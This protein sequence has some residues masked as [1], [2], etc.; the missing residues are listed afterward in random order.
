MACFVFADKFLIYFFVALIILHF[1]ATVVFKV[2]SE[3]KRQAKNPS[4]VQ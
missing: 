4:V 3:D 2:S 1:W